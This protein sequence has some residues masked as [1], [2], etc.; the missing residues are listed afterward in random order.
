MRTGSPYHPVRPRL[1]MPGQARPTAAASRVAAQEA[2][3]AA[4]AGD[5]EAGPAWTVAMHS[6]YSSLETAGWG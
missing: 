6:M 1:Q 3:Y 2:A 4:G 5:A